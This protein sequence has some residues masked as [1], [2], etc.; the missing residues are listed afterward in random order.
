MNEDQNPEPATDTAGDLNTLKAKYKRDFG[1]QDSRL[2]SVRLN[3]P[4]YAYLE[5]VAEELHLKVSDAVRV[6]LTYAGMIPLDIKNKKATVR[7]RLYDECNR[8]EKF[9]KQ[10]KLARLAV[11]RAIDEIEA[12]PPGEG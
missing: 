7:L 11:R 2:L 4:A 5:G 6:A 9:N 12:K 1:K 10:R 8:L 3:K